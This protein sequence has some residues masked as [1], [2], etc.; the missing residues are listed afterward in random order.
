MANSSLRR[1]RNAVH[2]EF[3]LLWKE[4]GLKRVEA[5]LWLS[6]ELNIN[7]DDCH[8]ALFDAA[9]CREALEVLA[10]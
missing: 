1:L 3:D 10:R 7:S 6:A 4:G 2:K 8:V 5:Y 9:T